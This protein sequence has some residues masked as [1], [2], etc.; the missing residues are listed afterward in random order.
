MKNIKNREKPNDKFYT[1]EPVAIK[2][3]NMC[4]ILDGESV[5]DPS[6]GKGVFYNNFPL[7]CNKS[8]CEIEEDLDFFNFNNRVDWVIGN[9]PYSLWSKWLEHTMK[10]TDK[11]CYIF[12]GFNFTDTRIRSIL[13]NGYGITAFHLLKI[14]WWLSSSFVVVFEKNKPFL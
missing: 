12:G 8:Y 2:M 1:P 3:I 10:I 5:L 14:D 9:P 13:N 6:K 7:N 11:F 4:N